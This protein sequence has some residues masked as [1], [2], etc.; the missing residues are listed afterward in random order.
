LGVIDVASRKAAAFGEQDVE[1]LSALASQLAIAIE[2][3]LRRESLARIYSFG[4]RLAA[5]SDRDQIISGTLNFLVEQFG[6]QLN[7]ILLCESDGSLS[8]AGLRGPYIEGQIDVGSTLDSDDGIVGWVARQKRYALVGDVTADPRYRRTFA[9]AR[10]ELA[11]PVLFSGNLLGI[12]D[13][14]SPQPSFFDEEDRQL[15]EVVANHLAISLSN[16]TSQ[17]SLREQAIRDPLTGLFNRHYF[18]SIITSELSRGDRYGRPISLM[19]IDID[20]FRAVNN[21]LGHLKGDDVLRDVATMLQ[22]N[23]R[24]ADRV[25]RYGGDEFL[26][27]MPETNGRGDAEIVADRLRTQ[28]AVV[29]DTLSSEHLT[30]GLSIGIYTRLPHEDRPLE[31]ILEEVDRRMY[32]DKRSKNDQR[33]DEYRR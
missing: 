31:S 11:V 22:E 25:I 8:V 24:D 33:A 1:V 15:L 3:L 9:G 30:L 4:Q 2:S 26:V 18:N 10:S 29:S 5:S 19:M 20:G 32:A 23:V 12:I 7:I 13:V 6:Y 14:E 27:F 28:I 16:L 21:R 17:E